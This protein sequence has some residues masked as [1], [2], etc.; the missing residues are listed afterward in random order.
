V[1]DALVGPSE[2]TPYS[3]GEL[4]DRDVVRTADV[5]RPPRELSA[6]G[7][8]HGADDVVD[9][10]D[11][12][13]VVPSPEDGR[14]SPA[15][16]RPGQHVQVELDERRAPENGRGARPSAQV[17]LG[18]G[19][20]PEQGER[21]IKSGAE[22]GEQD[23]LGSGPRRR[24][25]EHGV[26]VPVDVARCSPVVAG[27]AV[28]GGDDHAHPGDGRREGGGVSYVADGDLDPEVA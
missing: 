23:H 20:H 19:L 10:D 24:V 17:L 21:V 5:D 12:E 3:I 6:H 26:T 2:P 13:R 16:R 25:D 11:V 15:S 7:C 22:N 28:D 27:E 14:G 4:V 1:P 18:G 9:G 8:Q